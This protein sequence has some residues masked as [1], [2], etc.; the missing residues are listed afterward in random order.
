MNDKLVSVIVPAYNAANYILENLQ[1]VKNQSYG[2]W[3]CIVVNDGS[4]DATKEVVEN[5]IKDDPR[6]KLINTKNSGV[7]A[8]RNKAVENSNGYFL[9]PLDSDDYIHKDCLGKC[10]AEFEKKKDIKLV[11]PET[12]LVG[13]QTGPWVLPPFNYANMLKYNMVH[14]SSMFLRKDFDSVG[15]YRTN[16]IYGFEDWDFFIAL[17]Y[18]CR[19]DQVVK[20]NERLFYYRASHSGRGSAVIAGNKQKEMLDCIVFNNF[21]IYHEYYPEIFRRIHE[22]DYLKKMMEKKPIKWVAGIL[23][24]IS[25]IKNKLIK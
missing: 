24:Q 4:T 7:A 14:N 9:F 22:Y 11:C 17:L 10:V 16:M 5:F 23:N 6:F 19:D 20:L 2:N 21:C 25:V 1:S 18:G 13:T 8:A 12:E 15:G 3:E